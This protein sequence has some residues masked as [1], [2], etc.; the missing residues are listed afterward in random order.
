MLTVALLFQLILPYVQLDIKYYDLG[1]EH[2]DAVS[3]HS[4]F[5]FSA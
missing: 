3:S 1:L 4:V 2:R 5:V